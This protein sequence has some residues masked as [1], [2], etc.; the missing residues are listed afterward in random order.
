MTTPALALIISLAILVQLT[1]ALFVWHR[2]RKVGHVGS[3]VVKS[4]GQ[5]TELDMHSGIKDDRAWEGVK[6]FRVVRRVIENSAGD[7]CSL[8]LAPTEQM[9]LPAFKP[10]QFITFQFKLPTPKG[11]AKRVLRSYSLSD[12]PQPDTYRIS[13]KRKPGGLVSNYLHDQIEEGNILMVKAPSGLFHLIEEP[14]LPLV[15]IAGGIGITPM[16]SILFSLLKQGSEREI[17]LFYGVRNGREVIMRDQLQSLSDCHSRFHLHLCYSRP[18]TND[19]PVI[20]FQHA[21]HVDIPLLQ[22]MLKLDRYQF[23]VCGPGAM[24][25]SIVPGLESI[26]VPKDDIHYEAFGPATL[27]R[28]KQTAQDKDERW[29]V[30][31]T[32]SGRSVEWSEHYDSLLNIAEAEGVEVE[33]GCR[34]G[35]CG[36]CQSLLEKGEVEY[37]QK[38]IADVEEGQCL[39]CISRPKCDLELAL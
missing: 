20:D 32:R 12:Q 6:P 39:L 25:E 18:D 37:L 7:I 34:A 30:T 5:T 3:T 4:V 16:L 33:S 29:Q 13:V 35:S 2:R 27:R 14:P 15:L 8:Y 10:G 38:P 1:V 17:W 28:P 22:S 19:N 21:G 23:Y 24:I 36:G 11:E 9:T 26:G 31:F